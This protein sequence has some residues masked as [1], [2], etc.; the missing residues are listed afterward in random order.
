MY[1][2]LEAFWVYFKNMQNFENLDVFE[3]LI[4]QKLLKCSKD[5]FIRSA[6]IYKLVE[7]NDDC[8]Q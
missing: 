6:L 2:M 8:C 3:I 7:N 1:Y 4:T 5:P